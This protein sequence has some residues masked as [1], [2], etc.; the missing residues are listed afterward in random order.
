MGIIDMDKKELRKILRSK[1]EK[2][3]KK[4]Y[5]EAYRLLFKRPLIPRL[6]IL[7]S[8]YGKRNVTLYIKVFLKN[9]ESGNDNKKI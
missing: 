2:V 9:G 4:T 7:S 6:V 8:K 1:P 3:G 5:L